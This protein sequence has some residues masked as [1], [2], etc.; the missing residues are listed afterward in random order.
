LLLAE[1]FPHI[2]L[3]RREFLAYNEPS[4]N[5]LDHPLLRHLHEKVGKYRMRV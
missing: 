4:K 1:A 3:R 5:G 2:G